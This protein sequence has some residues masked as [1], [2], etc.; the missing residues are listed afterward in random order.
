[1]ECVVPQYVSRSVAVPLNS[2]VPW[3]KSTFP[4]YA[5]IFLW[6][7]FYLKLA[8]P[9]IGYT[10][11]IAWIIG[12]LVGIPEHLP[13]IPA[14]WVKADNP[15]GLYSFVVGFLVY[16]VL[17]KVGLRSPVAEKAISTTDIQLLQSL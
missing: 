8:E 2:R 4:A 10:G 3:Y 9:T 16:L 17:A 1:M 13:G 15:S 7:G 5:G 6:V 12:F 11:C 14:A